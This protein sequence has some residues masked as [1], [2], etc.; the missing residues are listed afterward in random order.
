MAFKTQ[1]SLHSGASI[2]DGR[3]PPH[4][5]FEFEGHGGGLKGRGGCASMSIALSE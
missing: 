5:D 4:A 3:D 2:L 1:L